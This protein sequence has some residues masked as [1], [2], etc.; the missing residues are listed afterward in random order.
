MLPGNM[1][2]LSNMSCPDPHED[3]EEVRRL[4]TMPVSCIRYNFNELKSS[5]YVEEPMEF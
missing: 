2:A 1:F 5:K 4:E 3:H